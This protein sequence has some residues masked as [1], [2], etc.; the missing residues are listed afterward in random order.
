[1]RKLVSE[2]ELAKITLHHLMIYAGEK[3]LELLKVF[4]TINSLERELKELIK[5]EKTYDK[6]R[7]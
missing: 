6:K 2:I 7:K 3:S 5:K 4:L 1:M